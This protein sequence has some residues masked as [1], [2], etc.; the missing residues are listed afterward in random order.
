L[1][2]S[3]HSPTSSPGSIFAMNKFLTNLLAES[4]VPE[5][6]ISATAPPS[7]HIAPG[8]SA[9]YLTELPN[10]HTHTHTRTHTHAHTHTH[11]K[12]TCI[13]ACTCVCI[14]SN[15]HTHTCTRTPTHLH[16]PTPHSTTHETHIHSHTP[17]SARWHQGMAVPNTPPPCVCF[18]CVCVCEGE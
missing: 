9:Q 1:E 14:S 15:L 16:T 6:H 4:A 7:T 3:F 10:C 2:I 5:V 8:V 12:C 11:N 18:G 13:C 17:D